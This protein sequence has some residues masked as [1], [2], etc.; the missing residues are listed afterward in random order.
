MI[1][2]VNG[3]ARLAGDI[4]GPADAQPLLLLH[5]LGTTRELWAPQLPQLA[6]HFRVVRAD[7]RGHGESAVVDGEYSIDELG[8][9]ALAVLDAVGVHRA[10]VCGLSIGGVTAIWLAR[11]AADRVDRIVLANAAARIGTVQG[12][13]DRIALV[14]SEGLAPVASTV[15]GRWF[16]EP[17]ADGHPAVVQTY[18]AMLLA[19]SPEGYSACAAALRDADLSPELAHIAA[20]ALVIAGD[21]DPATTVADAERLRAGLRRATLVRLSAAHLSNVEQADAFTAAALDFLHGGRD[22]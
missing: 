3:A 11:Y 8:R 22:G 17:F 18:A 12:W 7:L 15:R 2:A 14:R 1:E 4:S 20:P 6:R 19:T 13:S 9:D 10:S 16:T 21:H 5:S